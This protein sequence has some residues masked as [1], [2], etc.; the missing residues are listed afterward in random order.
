MITNEFHDSVDAL[1]ALLTAAELLS[2]HGVCS[3]PSHLKDMQQN[4][5]E[6]KE[7]LVKLTRSATRR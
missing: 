4:P 5:E 1:E 6:V 2:N 7:M 3:T